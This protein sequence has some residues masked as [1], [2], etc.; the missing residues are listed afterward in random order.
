MENDKFPV[1]AV[2]ILSLCMTLN[3]Y[4]MV[5]LFPYVGIM[6]KGLLRLETTNELGEPQV[7][8]YDDLHRVRDMFFGQLLF[9]IEKFTKHSCSARNATPDQVY[10]I[11]VTSLSLTPTTLSREPSPK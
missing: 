2:I 9:R 8:E 5:S 3:S 7:I 4:T 6:V 11:I 10:G 1:R